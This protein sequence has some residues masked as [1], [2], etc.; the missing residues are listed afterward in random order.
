MQLWRGRNANQV[1]IRVRN[2]LTPVVGEVSG[3]AFGGGGPRVFEMFACDRG[4]VNTIASQ[5]FRDLHPTCKAGTYKTNANAILHLPSIT[6][7]HKESIP[8]AR[9]KDNV[10]LGV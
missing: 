3:I 7:K 5:K 8:Y 1:D 2:R 6:K 4:D 10:V 9:L